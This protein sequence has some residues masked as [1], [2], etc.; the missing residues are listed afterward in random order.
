MIQY[1]HVCCPGVVTSKRLDACPQC[2]MSD[3]ITIEVDKEDQVLLVGN[4]SKDKLYEGRPW[5][6]FKIL[7][8][9]PG[10][11]VKKL[12]IK[13]GQRTSLQYHDVRTEHWCVASGCGLFTVGD[14][15]IIAGYG[16]SFIIPAGLPHRL[17]NNDPM[18]EGDEDL[19]VIETQLGECIENDIVRLEDDYDRM[20]DEAPVDA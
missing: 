2:G 4:F 13:P 10:I 7:L 5:G 16:S 15:E 6:S 9:E 3:P 12:I 18:S 20:D 1:R 19:I 8:D 14:E 17:D 11:K